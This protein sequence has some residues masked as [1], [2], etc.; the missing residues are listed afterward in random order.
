[1]QEEN[2]ERGGIMAMPALAN[3]R[4]KRKKLIHHNR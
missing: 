4:K 1:M 2:C 3:K